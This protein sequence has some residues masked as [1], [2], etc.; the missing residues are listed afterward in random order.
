MFKCK[1]VEE[2]GIEARPVED[3][4]NKPP[5]PIPIERGTMEGEQLVSI[6]G[7]E[8]MCEDAPVSRNQS[9]A[10]SAELFSDMLLS[11]E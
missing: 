6:L 5:L 3:A 9:L 10:L 2:V 8:A 11:V 1:G 7:W 4:D